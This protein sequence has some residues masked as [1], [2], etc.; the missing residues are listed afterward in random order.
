MIMQLSLQA[1]LLFLAR[2]RIDSVLSPACEDAMHPPLR[3]FAR[4]TEQCV[5]QVRFE[6]RRHLS[7]VAGGQT[8]AAPYRVAP[9]AT[10][11]TGFPADRDR[12]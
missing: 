6:A 5:E 1:V 7:Y 3:R 9:L 10:G 2:W 11:A 4:K 12:Q 8:G